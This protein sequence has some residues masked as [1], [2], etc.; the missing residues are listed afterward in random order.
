MDVW[1]RWVGILNQDEFAVFYLEHACNEVVREIASIAG[2]TLR[3][4][5]PV[6]IRTKEVFEKSHYPGGMT[7]QCWKGYF[8]KG[9]Y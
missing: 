6:R 3:A 1:E 7:D 5:D 2:W 4:E 9:G 8:G